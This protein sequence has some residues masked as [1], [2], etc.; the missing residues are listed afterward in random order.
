MAHA[1]CLS[2]VHFPCNAPY[3]NIARSFMNLMGLR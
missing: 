2:T 1:L 3:G